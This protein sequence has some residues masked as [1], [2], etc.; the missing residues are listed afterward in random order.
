MFTSRKDALSALYPLVI[1]HAPEYTHGVFGN[2]MAF[3][4]V[5]L[6]FQEVE[7]SRTS[8]NPSHCMPSLGH[9]PYSKDVECRDGMEQE[10]EK[11]SMTDHP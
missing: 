2:E 8:L 9:I 1:V 3:P 10:V 6:L 5:S 11:W 4:F 7:Y